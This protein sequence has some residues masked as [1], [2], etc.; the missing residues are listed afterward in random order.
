MYAKDIRKRFADYFKSKGHT[1]V[2]SSSLIPYN[3]PT[4]LFT[5]AGMVQFKDV[6]LGD[7]TR[8]YPRAVSSQ[9]CVRAGGKHNDLEN[10]GR[11]ARHHTF[12]EMLG[13]F[14]F[15][16]YFKS[17]AI[18]LAWDFLTKVM[19][20][21]K[22]R[23]WITIFQDDNESFEIWHKK[24]G[25]SN[26]RIVRMGKKDNFW[27]MGETGPCGPCSEIIIDQGEKFNCGRPDCKVGCDCDR[28][29]E[30]WN[31]V[32]MQFNRDS[33]G[34][35]TPLP[36]PSIDTGIG[37]ERITAVIQGVETNFDTD[38]FQPI[39]KSI[40]RLSKKK[41]R[42]QEKDTVSMRVIA[43]HIRAISFLIS[44]GVLP[45]NEGRG[46]VLRRILR[47]AIRHGKFLGIDKPF[48]FELTDVVVGLMGDAYPEL[49]QNQTLVS[50]VTLSE[51]ERFAN[52]LSQALNILDELIEKIKN[53]KGK[54]IPGEDIFKL[55]DTYGLP[56]DIAREIAQE[57]SLELDESG[58][59]RYM[60]EQ[61]KR[62]RKSWQGAAYLEG[63][64]T[65]CEQNID[66]L[67]KKLAAEIPPTTFIGYE[68][69]EGE[70]KVL[71]L[72]KSSQCRLLNSAREGDELEII[73]DKT[74]F[75]GEKGGQV[76]D[77]GILTSKGVNIKIHDAQTPIPKII[78]HHGRIIQ[79]SITIGDT[80]I[81]KVDK[82]RRKEIARNHTAT[83]LLQTSLRQ[84]LGNHVKQAGSLVSSGKLRFDFT[85]FTSINPSQLTKIEA[86]VNKHIRDNYPLATKKMPLEE[87]LESGA[88]ALF[89]E[90]Y[91]QGVRV[92][93]IAEV[94]SELCGGT[95]AQ[96][97]GD[98][99]LFKIINEGSVAA[100]VRRIEA[101]TGQ[102]AYEYI[103]KEEN[104]LK[105]T[106][107]LLKSSPEEILNRVEKLLIHVKEQE[108]EIS[109]LKGT[110]TVSQIDNIITRGK[111][112]QIEG[113][114]IKVVASRVDGIDVKGLRD[115]ADKIK[116][117]VK[118][119]VIVLGT[120]FNDKV[121][122]V[123]MVTKDL[124]DKLNAG[125]IVNE[126]AQI[127]GGSGG[128]R[129]DMAQA[130]G[131]DVARLDEALATVMK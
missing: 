130:G 19:G 125:K 112:V 45:S 15:G 22:E 65:L 37:L 20:L 50:S 131:K 119:G 47:R 94:S 56:L 25:T 44:D 72:V 117:K 126:L 57:S 13:N 80:L 2:K 40:E 122:L 74:P 114:E 87:A 120:V 31:L 108:K 97:T 123:T 1:E 76:G 89:G 106:A 78:S 23:L 116:D 17:E 51:E 111:L 39:L 105:E 104:E 48:L 58:F 52:T 98:I 54:S 113:Q 29:L 99:G 129:A 59:E 86:L 26:D 88:M 115:L 60:E 91:E 43:D 33:Q 8:P 55:Y 5:N 67:Y 21:P 79:G 7:E 121:A 34:N 77:T 10:V 102:V 24:I 6:F 64:I 109:K 27:S 73:L 12:F 32:F 41:Y 28:Y 82:E 92:V 68:T 71:A 100:G 75:Y 118:T 81:V 128:G 49:K 95:H 101:L 30:L 3:D 84:I 90:K 61:R 103:L 110:S 35:L 46:Y 9:K 127:C 62:G 66:I 85:H 83:H 18:P 93:N 11:T 107:R 16:D 96:A 70:A 14:S 124:T 4:L 36:K 38:L 63:D 42:G 69:L 53:Q